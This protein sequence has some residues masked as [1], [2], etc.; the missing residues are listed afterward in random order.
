[1]KNQHFSVNLEA[2]EVRSWFAD[3]LNKM[4]QTLTQSEKKAKGEGASG[5]LALFSLIDNLNREIEKLRNAKFRFLI[6]GDFNRGKSSILNVLFGQELLPMGVSATT[7]IPTFVRYGERQK[8]LVHKKD[9]TEENLSLEEYKK[10]YTLNSKD[11]K[12]KIKRLY[13]SV[14]DWL[15]P[16]DYADFHYPVELL[17]RGVEFIDTAGLNHT[18]EEDKKTLAYIPQC[19]AILFVLSAEQQL[20]ATEK[21]YLEK[22]IKDK[23]ETVFFLVNKWE[24]VKES[25]KEEIHDVFVEELSKCLGIEENKVE[26]MWGNT[27]FDVYAQTALS[28]LTKKEP[29]DGTGFIEF[30]NRL[31][32]FLIHERLIAELFSS[33]Q[34]ATSVTN[35]VDKTVDERSLVLNETVKSL[36]EKIKKV[37]PHIDVM[38]RIV[39]G[40]ET[41][42]ESQKKACIK[43]IEGEY[44]SYFAQILSKIENDFQMP[45]VDGLKD[46]QKEEYLKNLDKQFQE[47]QQEKLKGWKKISEGIVKNTYLDLTTLF[48]QDNKEY[49]EKREEIKEILSEKDL[50]VQNPTQSLTYQTSFTVE[51]SFKVIDGSA[52]GKMILAGGGAT[53][54]T[55]A[56]G[57]GVATLA[58]L[59]GGHILLGT[60]GAGLA[61]T[62]VG[63][64]LIGLSLLGGGVA[65]RW[66]GSSEKEKFKKGMQKQLTQEFQKLLEPDKVSGI[67]ESVGALFVHFENR[68]KDMKDD[69]Q[70]LQTS[71][72]NLLESKRTKEVDYEAEAQRLQALKANISAQWEGINAKYTEIA[73]AKSK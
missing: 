9:G 17:S 13:N 45:S 52:T 12:D 18:A 37:N 54:G 68:A 70:S 60:I 67:K 63:W 19:H 49:E 48:N 59:A 6:I 58:N 29:L 20:T 62:P 65:A 3:Q 57:I 38:K 32:E 73:S 69:V 26:K 34:T 36:E 46:N 56:S 21:D 50:S 42:T 10:K 31:D 33:V 23:V 7:A 72:K 15:N 16:L 51:T 22:F 55:I 28:K 71:L 47:Y 43:E 27:I 4:A 64:G 5:E 35:Q 40:L 1:M 14:G 53:V 39:K 2:T 30:S 11:V 66:G 24:L 41:Q 44:Q 61:L 8:V 25:D